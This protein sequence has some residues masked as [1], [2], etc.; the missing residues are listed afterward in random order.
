MKHKIICQNGK[1]FDPDDIETEF[2]SLFDYT[3]IVDRI[4]HDLWKYAMRS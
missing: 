4:Q 2:D 3:N 1:C